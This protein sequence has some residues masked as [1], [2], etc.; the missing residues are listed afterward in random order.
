LQIGLCELGGEAMEESDG[1]E[2]VE[3]SKTGSMDRSYVDCTQTGSVWLPACSV[4][5]K[6]RK[7]GLVVETNKQSIN[8]QRNRKCN[9]NALSQTTPASERPLEPTLLE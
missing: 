1:N 8:Q 4:M 7:F 9:A 2:C 3:Q 5:R 6:G